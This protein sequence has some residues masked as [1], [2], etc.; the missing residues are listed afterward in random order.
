MALKGEYYHLFAMSQ[1]GPDAFIILKE[2]TDW[3]LDKEA[4]PMT[5]WDHLSSHFMNPTYIDLLF[6]L[7]GVPILGKYAKNALFNHL[8]YVYDA[9]LNYVSAHEAVESICE[10]VKFYDEINP[11]TP[12][13][14]SHS[15]KMF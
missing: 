15:K 10:S 6:Y 9:S 1:C 5:S 13:H 4:Y 2:S 8:S 12:L 11:L 7:K 14:S 3:D